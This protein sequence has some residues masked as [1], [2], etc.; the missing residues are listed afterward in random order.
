MGKQATQRQVKDNEAIAIAR[1]LRTSPRKLGLVAGSIRGLPV[2]KALAEL[3]FSLKRISGPVKK[4]LESA[5]AN[6]EN[7]HS[8]N[9]DNLVV[10]EAQVGKSFVMKRFHTRGR[11]RSAR[12]QKW[13]SH[14]RIVVAEVDAEKMKAKKQKKQKTQGKKETNKSSSAQPSSA[15]TKE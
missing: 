8:L 3:E 15:E 11:G 12:V 13:F 7:N 9:I 2:S 1:N 5:I 14:L 10:K 4:T 6:A